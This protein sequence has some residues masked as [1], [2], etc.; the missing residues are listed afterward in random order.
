MLDLHFKYVHFR[1]ANISS[2]EIN[3]IF[4]KISKD[5]FQLP[6]KQTRTPDSP[7]RANGN[8]TVINTYPRSSLQGASGD[9]SHVKWGHVIA[10]LVFAGILSIRAV[11]CNSVET[12]DIIIS[13]VTKFF[14]TELSQW[15]AIQGGWV[16]FINIL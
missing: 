8:V 14:E 2:H 16:S 12:V 5:L 13:W 4:S 9:E 15:F 1:N 6:L 7:D 10:L 11:T 3:H